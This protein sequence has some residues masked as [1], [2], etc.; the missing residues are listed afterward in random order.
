MADADEAM[1]DLMRDYAVTFGSPAGQ[2]VL[3]DLE[4]FGH[5]IDP[6]II[7]TAKDKSDRRLFMNEGRREVLLRITKFC[8]FSIK[9]IYDLRR[10]QMSLRTTEGAPI[11]V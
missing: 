11:D 7:D 3:Q 9:D 2:R 1:A 6:L 8:N 4:V 5:L 10:G